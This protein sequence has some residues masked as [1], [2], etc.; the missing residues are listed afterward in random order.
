MFFPATALQNSIASGQEYYT[1][2]KENEYSNQEYDPYSSYNDNKDPII[3]VEKKLFICEDAID[4]ST[5]FNCQG[6][7]TEFFSLPAGPDSGDYVPCNDEICFIDE[8]DFN[9][10][11]FKEVATI[12]GLSSEGTPVNLDKF[13]YTVTE[14]TIDDIITSDF[15][16][17][18]VGFRH[19]SSFEKVIDDNDVFYAMC[20]NY[21]GDCEGT[22]YPGE[23]KTCTIE[24]YIFFGQILPIVSSQTD[25]DEVNAADNSQATTLQQSNNQA[26]QYH[27]KTLK[28]AMNIREN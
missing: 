7:A 8:S 13:H 3:N 26:E 9:A 14:R 20:V 24:N 19:A 23:V 5:D 2:D 11:I 4:N 12:Q 22:A 16:C 21:V 1:E 10:Q 27:F 28:D 18:P 15:E 25:T 6:P 17:S